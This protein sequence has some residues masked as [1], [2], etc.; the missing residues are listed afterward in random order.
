LAAAKNAGLRRASELGAEYVGLLDSNTVV[1]PTWL[2]SLFEVLEQDRRVGVVTSKT[3]NEQTQKLFT[4]GVNF[5]IWG[6]PYNRGRGQDVATD[7]IEGPIFG[8]SGIADLFRASMLSEVGFFD[9]KFQEYYDDTD[10]SFR[11]Q[12]AGWTVRYQPNAIAYHERR[13]ANPKEFVSYQ[14]F[15]NLPLLF[16]KNVPRSLFAG[17]LWRF[18]IAYGYFFASS[19]GRRQGGAAARG[20]AAALMLMPRA[21]GQ[22]RGIRSGRTVSVGYLRALIVDELPPNA[23]NLQR[24]GQAWSR[25]HVKRGKRAV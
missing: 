17:M 10:L 11:I 9:E 12:T 3:I 16:V 7:F 5:T 6:F 14:T 18:A 24:L 23:R 20:L 4:T 2:E 25:V 13:A 21:L 1:V 8:V 19:V 22:R 15:K